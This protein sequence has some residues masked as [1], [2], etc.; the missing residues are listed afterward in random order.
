VSFPSVEQ[1]Q[2]PGTHLSGRYEEF[3][4]ALCPQALEINEGP[5]RFRAKGSNPT[6]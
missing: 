1:P 2:A 3:Y 5:S 6:D 4:F